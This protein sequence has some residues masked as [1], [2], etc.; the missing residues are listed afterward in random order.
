ML[1]DYLLGLVAR[2]SENPPGRALAGVYLLSRSLYVASSSAY[3]SC[4]VA[5]GLRPFN[6]EGFTTQPF[7]IARLR[8]G[9]S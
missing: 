1:I 7:H 6:I 3:S 2:C 9:N 5:T 8:H 4:E